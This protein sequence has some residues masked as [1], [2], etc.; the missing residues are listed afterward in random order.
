MPRLLIGHS[1]R[2]YFDRWAFVRHAL[3]AMEGLILGGM[4]LLL[5]LLP[6]DWASAVV[7]RC[8]IWA[9]PRQPRHKKFTKNFALAFPDKS[10][11]EIEQYAKAAWGNLGSVFAEYSHLKRICRRGENERLEVVVKEEFE[12][13]LDPTKPA[14]FVSGH[15]AN[16]EVLAG[17]ITRLGIPVTGTYTPPANPWINRLLVSWRRPL[18]FK[19]VKRDES[20]RPFIKELASGR[21]IGLALDQ[22]VDSGELIPFF[23]IDKYTTL[24]PARLALRHGCELIPLRSERLGGARFRVTFYPPVRPDDS[25]LDDIDKARQMSHKVNQLLENWIIA[26]PGDWFCSKRIWPKDA[27][28]VSTDGS[29]PNIEPR[30]SET[31]LSPDSTC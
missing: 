30:P 11:E 1:L 24:V 31:V 6:P 2:K 13:L 15:L 8:F 20:V 9:G 16:W 7:A 23:G 18:G 21:S 22:R 3:W 12:S 25:A 27:R 14:V 19:L 29:H 4:N 17:A 10:E 5:R 28:P 26:R